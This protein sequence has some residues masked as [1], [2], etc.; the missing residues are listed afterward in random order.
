MRDLLE[1]YFYTKE[2]LLPFRVRRRQNRIIFLAIALPDEEVLLIIPDANILIG[3][4]HVF[5]SRNQRPERGLA[6]MFL[7]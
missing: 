5:A 3:R 1:D 4:Q 2:D 7:F 6:S